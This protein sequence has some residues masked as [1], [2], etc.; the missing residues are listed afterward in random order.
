MFNVPI[1]WILYQITFNKLI[2]HKKCIHTCSRNYVF[3]FGV[4]LNKKNYNYLNLIIY[5]PI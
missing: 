1:W 3:G 5:E 4:P 2:D